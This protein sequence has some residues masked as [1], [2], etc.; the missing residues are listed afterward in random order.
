MDAVAVFSASDNQRE[1][2]RLTRKGDI[3]AFKNFCERVAGISVSS[4]RK[5]QLIES[6]R[7]TSKDKSNKGKPKKSRQQMFYVGYMLYRKKPFQNY[8]ILRGA[9]SGGT[10]AQKCDGNTTQQDIIDFAKSKFF[11][12]G[13]HEKYGRMSSY[14]FSPGNSSGKRIPETLMLERKG[15]TFTLDNYIK[16]TYLTRYQFYC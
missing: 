16:T 6:I 11:T 13:F 3:W 12:N 14:V 4:N 1:S 15:V 9:N 5:L 2:L 7:M 10:R 8:K